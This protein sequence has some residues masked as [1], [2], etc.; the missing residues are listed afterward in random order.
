M[1]NI[2]QHKN[3]IKAN[4]VKDIN[5]SSTSMKSERLHHN[6]SLDHCKCYINNNNI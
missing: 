2:K 4:I 3:Y 5:S 1:F 6:L